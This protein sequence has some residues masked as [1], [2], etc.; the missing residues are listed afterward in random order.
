MN[1]AFYDEVNFFSTE[2]GELDDW[3]VRQFKL[4]LVK[5][6]ILDRLEEYLVDEKL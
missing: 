1:L 6:P 3:V 5:Y 2:F 4:G